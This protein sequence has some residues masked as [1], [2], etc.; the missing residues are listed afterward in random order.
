MYC[1]V[2]S[3]SLTS[4]DVAAYRRAS[5]ETSR[6]ICR[7]EV[8]HWWRFLHLVSG[9]PTETSAY[10]NDSMIKKNQDPERRVS[11][12]L[13]ETVPALVSTRCNCSVVISAYLDD[14]S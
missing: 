7:V 10:I 3:R 11:L 2:M 1:P 9:L 6:G 4:S 12:R 5:A 8:R 13:V 14:R